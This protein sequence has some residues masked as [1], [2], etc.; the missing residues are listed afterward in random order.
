MERKQIKITATYV[1][2]SSYEFKIKSASAQM[3]F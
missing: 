1:I 2:Y 3:F